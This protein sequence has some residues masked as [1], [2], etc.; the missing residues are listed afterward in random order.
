MANDPQSK[1]KSESG[2]FSKSPE[3]RAINSAK[4]KREMGIDPKYK[5]ESNAEASRSYR[6]MDNPTSGPARRENNKAK[7]FGKQS[8]GPR[9]D[10]ASF[11]AGTSPAN[12]AN[13][14]GGTKNGPLKSPFAQIS[15]QGQKP[16]KKDVAAVKTSKPKKDKASSGKMTNF[17]R[18][19]M[20]G[21]EK[22][23]Y[24][25]KSMT[26]KGAKARVQK[27]R[28]YKFKDLFKKK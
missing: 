2:I 6:S 15:L 3:D 26:S 22:E 27:E 20:R 24:G 5:T 12:K 1:K 25:G 11:L 7:S 18:S 17:E 8:S 28:S 4:Y 19:K 21:Y 16:K 10:R 14:V 23:G 9:D 13:A